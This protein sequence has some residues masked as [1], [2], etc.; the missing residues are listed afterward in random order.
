M[1]AFI[2]TT[3]DHPD[4]G[5]RV[6]QCMEAFTAYLLHCSDLFDDQEQADDGEYAEWEQQLEAHMSELLQGD[7][8]STGNLG[9]LPLSALDAEHLRDFIGWFLL[10]E[11]GDAELIQAASNALRDWI[12]FLH[13]RGWIAYAESV[14]FD[15]ILD[16]ITPA[17]VRTAKLSHVLFHF[18]RSAAGMPA[19]LRGVP[20]S[21]FVEGN[22]RVISNETGGICLA[23]DNREAAVGP[24]Q[25]PEPIRQ[26]VEIGDVFDVEAGL[27]AECWVM[28]DIGPIYPQSIYI[29]TEA[30]QGLDKIA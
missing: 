13:A 11:S 7:L 30:F 26:L 14:H 12:E 9:S 16:Q 15:D 5:V 21:D 25:L 24:L 19:Q 18:V 2:R 23:F 28:V 3:T 29:E 22:G 1:D 8:E 17:A 10:R 20:F 6:E 27:R 4:S